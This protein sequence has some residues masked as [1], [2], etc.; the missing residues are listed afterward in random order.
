MH[1]LGNDFVVIDAI[2]QKLRLTPEK[3]RQLAD[4]RFGIGFDQLLLVEVPGNPDVDFRYRIFNADGSEVENCGNGARCFARF[5]TDRKMTGKSSIRV[6]TASGN[7]VLHVQDS[8]DVTVDM[9]APRLHPADIPFD[10]PA[11]AATYPLQLADTELTISAVSMGNPHAVTVVAD[12]A[13]APVAVLGPQVESHPRFPRRVNAG[14]MEIVSRREI[15][16]RVYERGAGETLA[17]GTGAC[18]A[19][20]AGRLRDL[21]DSEVK[22]NLPGGSLTISWAGD[23]QPVMMTGPAVTVFH[24]QVKI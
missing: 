14:F 8:G 11:Q 24:G 6:E 19:V 12:A 9:G 16:L 10:A 21:L 4:R 13:T 22:V 1:G 3:I 20:V 18:A 23:G 7:M 2:S 5:V 15:N 17:C